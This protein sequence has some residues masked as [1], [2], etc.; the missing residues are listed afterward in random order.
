MAAPAIR[1]TAAAATRLPGPGWTEIAAYPNAASSTTQVLPSAAAAI[2]A[3]AQRRTGLENRLMPAVSQ[4]LVDWANGWRQPPAPGIEI[5]EAARYR[6]VLQADFPIAGPNSASW[7]RCRPEE[8]DEVIDQVRAEFRARRLPLMFVLDPGT[9]P[10]RFPE[11]LAARGIHPD[12]H[13]PKSAVMVLPI[14]ATIDAAVVDGL[15]LHDGLADRET[16]RSVDA[17]NTEAFTGAPLVDGPD[18]DAMRERR[19]LDNIAYGSRR[20]ILATVDGEPAGSAGL[21]LFPPDGATFNGGA[22]RPKFRGRGV[23]RAL[24]AARLEMA[25]E[26]GVAGVSVWGGPMSAPI[27]DRFGFQTVG[28]R[29]FYLDPSTPG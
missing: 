16:F 12:E 17:V 27:L 29:R 9:E 20:V 18:R 10:A 25:R 1:R 14:D 8:A 24:L 28:W 26:A 22:V 21:N 13:A 3:G 4:G 19:R 6:L 11:F 5:I 7:I 23:Y 2:L 15:E